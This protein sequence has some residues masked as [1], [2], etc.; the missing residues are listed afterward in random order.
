MKNLEMRE[1][2]A[3]E[4]LRNITE[5]DV[6]I[7]IFH[8]D[9][10]GI[11]SCVLINKFLKERIGKPSDFVI[12]QPMPITK[13]LIQ[14]I[15]LSIPTKIII[16]DLAIDQEKNLCKRLD[17]ISETLVIDHHQITNMI[18]L[19]K[20]IYYNPL[21]ERDV[22]QSTSYLT[23]KLC[24]KIINMK[25]YLWVS[26]VGIA[27]DYNVN[28]S[29]DLIEEGKNIYS[30]LIE[31]NIK[32]NFIESEFGKVSDIITAMRASHISSERI[33]KILE[34][35]NDIREIE[36]KRELIEYYEK[37]QNEI[38]GILTNIKSSAEIGDKILF[39]EINCKYNLRSVIST[40][41]SE[42]YS[43]KII[44]VWEVSRNKVKF[45]VR[46]QSGSIDANQ[47]LREASKDFRTAATG[48]HKLAAGG[49]IGLDEFDLFKEKIK[50]IVSKE[51][52]IELN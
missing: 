45:S 38:A 27:G 49:S 35:L 23:Y 44:F 10:D 51:K 9:T 33:A 24:S 25:K 28:D 2:R 6:V 8:N 7:T 11:C 21:L 30:D 20:I 31:G 14:R 15:K 37:V 47:L 4:F 32:K 42:L 18:N 48:G 12:S 16:L 50:Q 17:G 39:Y 52:L 41:L 3:V 46:N 5:K 26:L 22:Y 13:T 43:D 29:L 1:K 36:Q 40:K 34:G 19:K